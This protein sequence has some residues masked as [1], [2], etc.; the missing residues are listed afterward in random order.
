MMSITEVLITTVSE[1]IHKDMKKVIIIG[2]GAAGMMAAISASGEGKRVI[3]LER[4][5]KLGKKLFITGK[6]RCNITNACDAEEF[7]SHVATNSRFLY[8]SFSRFN[9]DDMIRLLN[10]AG[11]KT[12]VERGQ[13]VF[14]Q[15]DHSSD[16]IGTLKRLCES[17]VMTIVDSLVCALSV[18]NA[19]VTAIAL[20]RKDDVEKR[21]MALEEI[22]NEYDVYNRSADYN[23]F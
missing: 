12:K 23:S 21:L 8:S 13:R 9:N 18:V 5:E 6:G 3:L 1:R 4:N 11:L 17:D 15:S 7:L 14:P 10:D 16:V 22:W 2:G 19:L 20:Q